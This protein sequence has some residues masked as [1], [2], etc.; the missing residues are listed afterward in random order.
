[1]GTL[2]RS[3]AEVRAAIELSFGVVSG[4]TPGI[5]VLDGSPR[6]S[7]GGVVSGMVLGIFRHLRMHCFNRR[8]DA[9][10][11]IRFVCEKLTIFPYA[12]YIVEFLSNSLSYDVVR[13]KIKVGDEEKFMCKNVT[14]HTTWPL[15]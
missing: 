5:H 8:H 1:M 11:C 14:T 10:K 6:A 4:V 2:L 12:D 13:F 15:P 3:C 7:R 9:D